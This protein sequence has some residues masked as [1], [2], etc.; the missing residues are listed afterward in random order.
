MF[1][2]GV[3]LLTSMFFLFLEGGGATLGGAGA[4]DG[5]LDL[6]GLIL[7]VEIS[8]EI[9]EGENSNSISSF[10]GSFER[11]ALAGDGLGDPIL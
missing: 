3:S 7:G 8:G 10:L 1:E 4:N 5:I 2:L 11:G 6:L 9:L